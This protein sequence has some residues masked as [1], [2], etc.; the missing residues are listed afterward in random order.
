MKVM[1]KSS[2]ELHSVNE[3]Q[4]TECNSVLKLLHPQHDN[5][6]HLHLLW[7]RNLPQSRNALKSPERFNRWQIPQLNQQTLP[8]H[9]ERFR[10]AGEDGSSG[11]CF[12]CCFSYWQAWV[13][14]GLSTGN[15]RES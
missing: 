10:G 15:G 8:R 6:F 14:F 12:F 13:V 11:D 2:T 9:R 5:R 3:D 4:K 1:V 7:T